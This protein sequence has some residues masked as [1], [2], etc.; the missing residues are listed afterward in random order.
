ML[1]SDNLIV[2]C[3]REFPSDTESVTIVQCNTRR[4]LVRHTN[5]VKAG[6]VSDHDLCNCA[7]NRHSHSH[8][9]TLCVVG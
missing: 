1:H 4:D 9:L 8:P 7:H 6:P 2:A 5:R 3:F